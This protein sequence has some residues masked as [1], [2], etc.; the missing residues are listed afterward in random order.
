MAAIVVAACLGVFGDGVLSRSTVVASENLQIDYPRMMRRSRT[1]EILVIARSKDSTMLLRL[2]GLVASG[3][4]IETVTPAPEEQVATRTGQQLRW[5]VEPD[6]VVRITLTVS[7]Q[8]SGQAYATVEAPP[9]AG[10]P[11][12]MFVFP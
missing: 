9:H 1:E 2:N 3:F 6:A 10:T 7:A 4:T 8:R 5:R 11:L 12:T